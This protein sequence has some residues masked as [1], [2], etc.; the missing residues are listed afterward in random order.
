MT[1]PFRLTLQRRPGRGLAQPALLVGTLALAI[2]AN[3]VLF[4]IVNTFVFRPLPMEQPD[5]VAFVLGTDTQQGTNRARMSVEDFLDLAERN[6]SFAQ[7]SARRPAAFTWSGAGEPVRLTAHQATATFFPAWGIQIAHGRPFTAADDRPG[8][9]PVA[10]LS[11]RAWRQRFGGSAATLGQTLM[12]DGIAHTVIG[13]M[14]KG[15]EIGQLSLIEV[16]TPLRPERGSESREKRDLL[17]SGRLRDGVSHA[18]A[19]AEMRSLTAELRRQHPAT[20]GSW[21]ARVGTAR[22]GLVGDGVWL[23]LGFLGLVVTGVLVVAC[24]NVANV[25]LASV[26]ERRVEFATRAALGASARRI[27]GALL[28]ELVGIAALA[29]LGGLGLAY[30]GL[31]IVRAVAFEAVWELVVIDHRVLLFVATL[32]ATAILLAGLIPARDAARGELGALSD[33]S[34]SRGATSRRGSRLRRILAAAQ[35]AAAIVVVVPASL[36]NRSVANEANTDLGFARAGLM[37][38]EL[39]LPL[40]QYPDHESRRAFVVRLEAELDRGGE[41]KAT[42]V[43]PLPVFGRERIVGF[44][45]PGVV[46][47]RAEDRPRA[48]LV[49][50]TPALF[51][52]L[53][54]ARLAGEDLPREAVPGSPL[55]A[56]ANRAFV[57]RWLGDDVARALGQN[58][59]LVEAVPAGRGVQIVGVVADV[60]SPDV[61]KAPSPTLYLP[62]AALATDGL[63]VLVRA[64]STEIG[65]A[66]IRRAV[67]ATDPLIALE[68]PAS[69]AQLQREEMSS[70]RV[71][72][73]LFAAFA[74]I[75]V[76]LALVGLYAVA[77]FAIT[78]RTR[79]IGVRMALGADRN[80]IVRTVLGDGVRLAAW[81]G[82]SG[83]VLGA[84]LGQLLR[85]RLFGVSPLD[86][87]TFGGAAL[88]LAL[89]A[90]VAVALPARRAG[91][92]DPAVLLRAQ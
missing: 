70:N 27:F 45:L 23:T 49:G 67:R 59:L 3:T 11:D 17:V 51:A 68:R 65:A 61:T 76:A 31:R 75:A 55:R 28:A 79:E 54:V 92:V 38:A 19:S 33:G 47:E 41:G 32:A 35:L 18:A 56:V 36:I 88:G 72:G 25:L 58:V 8:A 14:P 74:G 7:L 21:D 30:L 13:V 5:Q 81:G 9:P 90:L 77:S 26:A 15:L 78:Q 44:D 29:A 80:R 69:F 12:L 4:S 86:P 84:A 37:T 48:I 57:S 24:A 62:L 82:G 42:L 52:T 63:A 50:A 43:D 46:A 89:F 6:Q 1:A 64:P 83:L 73:G 60:K 87:W 85:A 40:A 22:Q 39:H 71:I 66:E 2:A 91:G 20:N 16:W 53:G 10:L 34:G